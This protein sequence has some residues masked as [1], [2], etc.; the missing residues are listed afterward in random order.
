M[1][2]HW[3]YKSP[4]PFLDVEE[5][6]EYDDKVNEL[7]MKKEFPP[8]DD[9]VGGDIIRDCWIGEIKSAEAVVSRYK[10]LVTHERKSSLR[11]KHK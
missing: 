3:P 10:M 6:D 1:T 4:G 8:I 7:V 11:Q 2:G 5:W 9:L